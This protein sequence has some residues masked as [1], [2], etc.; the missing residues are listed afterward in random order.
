MHP[1]QTEFLDTLQKSLS[2]T[3]IF[4]SAPDAIIAFE[5]ENGIVSAWN[6]AAEALFGHS[7]AEVLGWVLSDFLV[8]P[9]FRDTVR[10]QLLL[11]LNNGEDWTTSQTL[12]LVA[13]RK[14]GAEFPINFS[15]ISAKVQKKWVSFCIA[16]DISELQHS[17]HQLNDMIDTL[18]LANAEL[19][20]FAHIVAH[21]LQEPVRTVVSFSQLLQRHLGDALDTQGREFL[22]FIIGGARRMGEQVR[23]LLSYV[24]LSDR[25]TN[26]IPLDL[27]TIVGDAVENLRHLIE[28]RNA[29]IDI[30]P[31]PSVIGDQI[32]LAE[33][34]Q[35][36][37]GNAIK[38]TP[39]DRSPLVCILA[40][41]DGGF[42]SL[43]VRDEGI[44][45]APEYHQRIFEL[46]ERINPGAI[47][48]GAGVGLTICKRIVELHG[49]HMWVESEEGHGATFKFTLRD[50]SK[51]GGT[52][53][54]VR[55]TS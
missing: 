27:N 22:A 2:W 37:I 25:H 43:A 11:P 47:Y 32:L 48:P 19:Q 53:E 36:L 50:G 26:H 3:E 31:L 15:R 54:K 46:F 39:N 8:P 40:H 55:L 10:N 9:R 33:L 35:N 5:A 18:T 6:P 52:P 41:R 14:D 12:E 16:R 1:L 30:C 24:L 45:I 29:N 20:R 51:T 38:F 28:E 7:H 13:L 21:D 42:W 49:G 23:A 44:G 4:K 17:E 34:F